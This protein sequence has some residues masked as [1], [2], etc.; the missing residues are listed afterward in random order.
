MDSENRVARR[1]CGRSYLKCEI[2]RRQPLPRWAGV[3]VL[4]WGG[5]QEGFRGGVA[6]LGVRRFPTSLPLF[7]IAIPDSRTALGA[8]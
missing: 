7:Y 1:R 6:L 2:G 4:G 5:V 3:S 8:M